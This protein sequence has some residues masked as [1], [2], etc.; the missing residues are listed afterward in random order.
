[1]GNQKRITP[2]QLKKK[3]AREKEVPFVVSTDDGDVE[4]GAMLFRAIGSEEYDDLLGEHPPTGEQRKKGLN[5]NPNT[6]APAL[7]ARVC[8]EPAMAEEEWS[9]IWQSPDWNRGELQKMYMEAVDV[10]SSGADVPFT[11]S[12]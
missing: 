10:C 7:L 12:D 3:R 1:M 5:H 4:E 11:K 6:F 8:V 9:D 2:D